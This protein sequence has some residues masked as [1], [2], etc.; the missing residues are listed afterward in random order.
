MTST[1]QQY[2]TRPVLQLLGIVEQDPPRPRV[3]TPPESE[4]PVAQ[5]GPSRKRKVEVID[6]D[7]DEE[8]SDVKPDNKKRLATRL[9]WLEVS[10]LYAALR[11]RAYL[12]ATIAKC[13]ERHQATKDQGAGGYS[14]FDWG[15]LRG[16]KRVVIS[17][18]DFT[19][20]FK[21]NDMFNNGYNEE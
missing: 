3:A 1:N 8:E 9:N 14:G 16:T 20:C 19:V 7:S 18:R 6:I 12:T 15:R 4:Q 17:F 21:N 5:A 11:C 2:R 10:V 13:P